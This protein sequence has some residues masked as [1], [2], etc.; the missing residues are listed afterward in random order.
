MLTVVSLAA[1]NG[2]MKDRTGNNYV[3][4]LAGNG[5]YQFFAAF[6]SSHLDY[7]AFYRTVPDDQAFRLVRE[8]LKT[9]DATFVSDDPLDI[10]RAIRRAGPEQHLN[11]VLISVESLSGD[12]LWARTAQGKPHAEPRRARQPEPVLR[13]PLRHRHAHRARPGSAGAVG[14]ADAGRVAS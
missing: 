7:A 14:A 2:D 12:L 6:R 8:G 9:P 10:T 3:N 13:Q 1:V 4:E 11:V 5:I